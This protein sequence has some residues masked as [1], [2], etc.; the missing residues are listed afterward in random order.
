[1]L[2]ACF[3]AEWPEPISK[4]ILAAVK[5]AVAKKIDD[6]K[7][8]IEVCEAQAALVLNRIRKHQDAVLVFNIMQDQS[9]ISCAG[10]PIE[11][12]YCENLDAK[13]LMKM[14]RSIDCNASDP[15][16][17]DSLALLALKNGNKKIY[18]FLEFHEDLKKSNANVKGLDVVALSNVKREYDNIKENVRNNETFDAYLLRRSPKC[19]DKTALL[20]E[21]SERYL[22]SYLEKWRSDRAELEMYQQ[23]GRIASVV[24][25]FKE[26]LTSAEQ[27]HKQRGKEAQAYL[28]IVQKALHGETAG[29]CSKIQAVLNASDRGFLN[30]SELH[31]AMIQLINTISADPAH[32]LLCHTEYQLSQ[33]LTVREQE[34]VDLRQKLIRIQEDDRINYDEKLAAELAKKDERLH[35][36]AGDIIKEEIA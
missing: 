21:S 1:M 13:R 10:L 34:I 17:G 26:L 8:A 5:V 19:V 22:R 4:P 6:L 33:L 28:S 12:R 20:L 24:V 11:K 29:F 3:E 15:I 23:R 25:S 32:A 35:E 31:D 18:S 16:L 2:T 7:M 30:G 27:C 14:A 36:E 9:N